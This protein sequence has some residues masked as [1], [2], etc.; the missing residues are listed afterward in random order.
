MHASRKRQAVAKRQRCRDATGSIPLEF[1]PLKLPP[2][3]RGLL[4]AE[5]RAVLP[6]SLTFAGF[7]TLS[8][9]LAA[10]QGA[11]E[12]AHGGVAAGICR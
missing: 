5:S 9:R 7:D 8:A 1:D 10:G 6:P 3:F 12:R 11:G 2:N 4:L